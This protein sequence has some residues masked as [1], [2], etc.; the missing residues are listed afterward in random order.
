MILEIIIQSLWLIL[1][2]YIANASAV[3]IG[4]GKPIDSGKNWRDGR[5]ILGDG[6]TWRGWF[7]GTWVGMTAGFAMIEINN[8]VKDYLYFSLT[9]FGGFYLMFFI[10]FALCFGALLGDI[11]E[12]FFKRRIGKDRGEDWFIFDQLDFIVGALVLVFITSYII[13]FIKPEFGSWFYNNLSI[14]NITFLLI[15]TPFI[16]LITN[17][18]YRKK[19]RSTTTIP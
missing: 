2:A 9:D 5:R 7:I 14:S 19:K 17:F 6:K 11:V 10:L 3:I 18:L 12:S 13:Q 4:G 1:P 15:V 8:Y 16:H